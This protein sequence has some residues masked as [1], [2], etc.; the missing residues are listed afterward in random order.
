MAHSIA[1]MLEVLHHTFPGQP[2]PPFTRYSIF[3]LAQSATLDISAACRDLNYRPRISIEEGF[4]L[5]IES[6]RQN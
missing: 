6:Q 5:F 4:R 3:V 1:G 2:E